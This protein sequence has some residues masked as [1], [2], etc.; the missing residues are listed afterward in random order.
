M[1][2]AVARLN[3][4]RAIRK[5]I[6][7]LLNLSLIPLKPPLGPEHLD[8]VSPN[9]PITVD[10]VAGYTQNCTFREKLSR[11]V[12]PTLRNYPGE[13][14][15]RRRVQPEGLVHHSFEI[16]KPFYNFPG[17]DWAVFVSEGLV[18]LSLKCGLDVGIMGKVVGDSADRA[19]K[20]IIS[21]NG[22]RGLKRVK[23]HLEVESEPAAN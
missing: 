12:Q 19:K 20:H 16:R 3:R 1:T 6:E 5:W 13:T 23:S 4:P 22:G 18:E 14:H 2:Q 8:I 11:N 9:L 17:C 15:G 10:S 21:V 7:H